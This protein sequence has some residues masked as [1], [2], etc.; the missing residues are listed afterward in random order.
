MTIAAAFR[1]LV[2]NTRQVRRY[3]GD[4]STSPNVLEFAERTFYAAKAR[5]PSARALADA[6]HKLVIEVE[7]KANY[8]CYGARRL[9]KHL[10]RRLGAFEIV[11]IARANIRRLLGG[12]E[13]FHRVGL[14]R[15]LRGPRRWS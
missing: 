3:M 15:L 7:W 11:R 6:D 14:S 5:P 4:L 8:S 1:L 2:I 12:G 10:R 13:W 9:H